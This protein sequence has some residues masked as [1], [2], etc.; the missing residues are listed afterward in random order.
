MYMQVMEIVTTVGNMGNEF[1][2]LAD[3]DGV[4]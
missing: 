4:Q 1:D 3:Y 2:N